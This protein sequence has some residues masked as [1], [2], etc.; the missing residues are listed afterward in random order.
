M[1]FIKTI[2]AAVLLCV[3][4]LCSGQTVKQLEGSFLEQ[5]EA[6]DSILIA[7]QLRYGFV[8]DDVEDGTGFAFQ[9]WSEAFGDTLVVVR[10]WQLDTL[11]TITPKKNSKEALKYRLRAHM[12]IAPFEAGTYK[13]PAPAVQR[14]SPSGLIDTLVFNP[15]EMV[16][17]T[18]PVDTTT[19]VIHDIKGQIRYPVTFKELV[20]YI[21]ALLL[22]AV[23][24]FV[25]VRLVMKYRARKQGEVHKDPPYIVALRKLEGFRNEKFWAPEKQKSFYSG[26][27]DTLR[28]Y[29]AETF[30]IDAR[31][32]TTAEIFSA[33]KNTK[34][35][36]TD[37]YLE[38]K[39]L[40]E[41]ADFVKFAK[42]VAGDEDNAKALPSAV[43]F[44]TSTYQKQL[45]EQQAHP[46]AQ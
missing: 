13:L 44:V 36:P 31:E 30:D 28:E 15:Q 34:E 21:I 46:D 6:R 33:L 24:I 25:I 7:D 8:L 17:T 35:I 3:S 10:N 11:K 20:P 41:T 5:L 43:R 19:F 42:H 27:T 29:I 18:I 37:L 22:A 2:S 4:M 39:E 12:V 45:D 40:F 23:L 26:I 38:A 16:V 9:D 14:T 32:M 1:R